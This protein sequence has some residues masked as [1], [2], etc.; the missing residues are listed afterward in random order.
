[1]YDCLHKIIDFTVGS[2]AV[3]IRVDAPEHRAAALLHIPI[4]QFATFNRCY[5]AKSANYKRWIHTSPET[6]M[7]A[8]Y[9]TFAFTDSG[10]WCPNAARVAK[11]LLLAAHPDTV[12]P[13]GP[14]DVNGTRADAAVELYTNVAI[15]IQSHNAKGWH[16]MSL[17][18]HG[19]GGMSHEEPPPSA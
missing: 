12:G 11:Q 4:A 18:Q 17:N 3:D 1:M 13:A 6:A 9:L 16:S 2:L 10:G 14:L 8:K 7:T 19:P 5:K 15:A